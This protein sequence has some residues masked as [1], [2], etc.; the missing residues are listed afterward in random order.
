MAPP[1]WPGGCCAIRLPLPVPLI[2]V[3]WNSA[4]H[5]IRCAQRFWLV[6]GN[7]RH[8]WR[9]ACARTFDFPHLGERRP[10]GYMANAFSAET[11]MISP[12]QPASQAVIDTSAQAC[13]P[14]I[15]T[16]GLPDIRWLSVNACESADGLQPNRSIHTCFARRAP[17]SHSELTRWPPSMAMIEPVMNRDALEASKRSAPSISSSW[18]SRRIG[19]RL[20]KALPASLCQK[21]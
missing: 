7:S 13:P 3:P 21:S 1:R 11:S 16:S 2:S 15:M 20:I 8:R 6:P 10:A 9:R 19:T 17:G 18:P 4:V 12:D 14:P 5:Q